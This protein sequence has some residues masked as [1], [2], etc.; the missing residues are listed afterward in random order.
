MASPVSVRAS[1]RLPTDVDS[2]VSAASLSC[3]ATVALKRTSAGT[4]LPASSSRMSPGTRSSLAIVAGWPSRRTVTLGTARSFSASSA[5]SARYSCTTPI[6]ALSRM[7]TR[8]AMLS[9]ISPSKPE[10]TAAAINTRIMKSLNWLNNMAMRPRRCCSSRRLGPCVASA[11]AACS[12]LI[13]TFGSTRSASA[14][15][16]TESVCQALFMRFASF[17]LLCFRGRCR[18]PAGRSTA[19]IA[20]QSTAFSIS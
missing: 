13:P 20:P 12:A 2:P 17:L 15:C 18:L 1:T 16:C 9:M 3:S 19:Y 6:T 8:I 5:R 4:R 14:V 7:M 11:S 10:T